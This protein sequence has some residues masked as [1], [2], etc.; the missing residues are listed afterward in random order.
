MSKTLCAK[1]K[2]AKHKKVSKKR[3]MGAAKIVKL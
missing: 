1:V 2:L 3:S